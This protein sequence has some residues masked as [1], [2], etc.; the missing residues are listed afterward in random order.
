M[1][2]RRQVAKF[3]ALFRRPEPMAELAEEIRTHLAMEEQENLEAGM[4]P[5]EAHYAALR[6]FGNVTLAREGSREMWVWNW[7][8]TLWQD[9]C[10]AVRGFCRAPAFSA[11]VILTLALGVGANGAVFSILQAVLLQPLPYHEPNRLIMVWRAPKRVPAGE[12]NQ[13]LWGSRLQRGILTREMVFDWREESASVF[14]GFAA[15]KSWSGNSDAEFDLALGD[16]AERLRGALV[17]PNF[18]DVLGVTAAAGRLF[19]A[20]DETS[21]EPLLVL[22]DGL[23]RRAF[24]ADPGTVGRRITLV[25]GI[26]PRGP[27]TFAVIGVLP[28]A[29]RF[30]YPEETEAWVLKPWAELAREPG[31]ALCCQVIARLR[32]D[33]TIESASTRVAAIRPRLDKRGI[34]PEQQ[35]I[36]RLERIEDWVVGDTR[37]PLLLLGAV[38]ALLLAITCATVANAL[39][40]RVTERQREIAVRASLGAGHRRLTRQLLTEGAI[41]SA[42]GAVAGT[43]MALLLVP[44]VRALVPNV[45]PRGGEIGVNTWLLAFGIG[46]TAVTT[47]AAAVVPAWR[48]ARADLISSLK[49]ASGAVAG[50]RQAIRW[51]FALVGVQVAVA[52]CLLV[53]A[54]LLL[55]SFWRLGH[56]PLGFDRERVLAAEMRLLDPRYQGRR[57][58]DSVYI[59]SPALVAFQ[60]DLAERVRALPGVLDAAVTSAVPF[61]GSDSVLVLSEVGRREEVVGNGRF[62]DPRYFSVMRIPL[63]R[64]RLFSETDTATSDNVAVVSESYA[65][66]M[67]G[68]RDPLGRKIEFDGPVEIVGVVRDARYAALEQDPR[69]T[70]YFVAAQFPRPV[71]SLVARL[72]P[73]AG[74]LHAAVRRI[75]HDLDP[76]LP[77]LHI[78]TVDEIIGEA[79]A[80]RRFYTTATGAFASVALLLTIVGL[81]VIVAR[82]TVERRREL[83]VRAALGATDARLVWLVVRQGLMPV[84]AGTAAGLLG[85][86]LTSLLLAQFLF[87]VTPREPA[88]YA[89]AACVIVG[90]ALVALVVPARCA[91]AIPPAA[92][93]NAE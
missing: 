24:G 19:A 80:L 76:A 34:P 22:S 72:A 65:R 13:M 66:Q 60:R 48:G 57:L 10:Y 21:A 89:A 32:T 17:T 5:E 77:I 47:M 1:S 18:F 74:D 20:A 7:A 35:R 29:F 92:V 12:Q 30:T 4:P 90:V 73:N 43:L 51:R 75:V 59:P 79:V 67:F 68:G 2:W 45:V 62:V 37:P 6:R 3:A 50:D 39:L 28:P 36:A 26:R 61:R 49:R 25:G 58:S 52:T 54:A 33:V 44:A 84:L 38:A 81:A 16:R 53:C 85:A 86:S 8:E 78:A 9:T 63:V 69:P 40:E 70:V 88:I 64:G 14:D 91:T 46:S 42:A 93:L 11:G 56:V 23:W 82:S 83:A 41:L 15:I 27:R 55:A 87:K 31:S 71:E